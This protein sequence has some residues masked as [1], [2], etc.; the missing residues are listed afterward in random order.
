MQKIMVDP[1]LIYTKFYGNR[2]RSFNWV[3]WVK[4]N[5]FLLPQPP[6]CKMY[7]FQRKFY[8]GLFTNDGFH[9]DMA[10]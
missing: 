9:C 3:A 4:P 5:F 10:W 2:K 1:V 8:R 6:L 7:D